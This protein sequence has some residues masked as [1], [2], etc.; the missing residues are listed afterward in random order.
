MILAN[1]VVERSWSQQFREGRRFAQARS[2]GVVK[3]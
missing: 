1:N 2:D 3:E